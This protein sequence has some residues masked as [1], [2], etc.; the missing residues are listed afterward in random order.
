MSKRKTLAFAP[1]YDDFN[2]F[3]DKTD[4][5]P[6]FHGSSFPFDECMVMMLTGEVAEMAEAIQN[7]LYERWNVEE[8]VTDNLP[9]HLIRAKMVEKA[10]TTLVDKDFCTRR[11]VALGP[12]EATRRHVSDLI[13]LRRAHANLKE[14]PSGGDLDLNIVD[15]I[16]EGSTC[17]INEVMQQSQDS[18]KSVNTA[19]CLS[20][21]G[22]GLIKARQPRDAS[23]R[24]DEAARLYRELLGQVHIDVA[25][26]VNALA[27]SL[28]KLNETRS[29][30]IRFGEAS[31]TYED[32]NASHHFDSIA[33]L[34]GMANLFVTS[35]DFQAATAL[36]EN[37]ISRKQTVHG[38]F[39]VATAKTINDCAVIL[40]KNNR[41]DDALIRYEMARM[42]YERAL[43]GL[44]LSMSWLNH[45]ES[46]AKCGFDMALI[47]L[48]IASIKSKKGDV[49]GA[50]TAYNVG[51]QGL[52]K[53][54]EDLELV[55]DEAGRNKNS[56]HMRHLVSALGRI[57]SLKLKQG[58]KNGALETY[59]S[60]F[61]E[62]DT[63]ESPTVSRL[64]K[65]K[66]HIKCATIYRG[67]GER[68]DNKHAIIHL[69]EALNMYTEL[70]GAN[71][72]DTIAVATSLQQWEEEH[73]PRSQH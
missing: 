35:G 33:N 55:G 48:N 50:I 12:I 34:Q 25:R 44:P 11:V 58:D 51:V 24:L 6:Q 30:L 27:K 7:S 52:R 4:V 56:S 31:S 57:G 10:S 39:S 71:N 29:A 8:Y 26:A 5:V 46:A 73:N 67:S 59:A 43:D 41:M 64:E 28:V 60:L 14:T 40:A 62:V 45:G 36:Y 18:P 19:I 70:Y 1:L 13:E 37:V 32:C 9:L 23:R 65:A 47:N 68:E 54:R 42:T 53:Y 61:K 49:T 16:Q 2:S 72:K 3:I 38:E 15:A 69:R 66:A 17:I 22:E 20:T 21:I 63:V